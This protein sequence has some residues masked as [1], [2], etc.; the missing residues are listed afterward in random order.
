MIIDRSGDTSISY[1]YNK[2]KG[3]VLFKSIK[4]SALNRWFDKCHEQYGK[5]SKGG[6]PSVFD[7]MG[8]FT[9]IACII[10]FTLYGGAGM[11]MDGVYWVLGSL[12]AVNLLAVILSQR[13]VFWYAAL[14]Y[15]ILL[16]L[17]VLYII[18]YSAHNHVEDCETAQE[19]IKTGKAE[20]TVQCMYQGYIINHLNE[21]K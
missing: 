10:L 1:T 14:C 11:G 7:M 13:F 21:F 6:D 9:I 3:N 20:E 16:Y 18:P 12:T 2:E 19:I 8:I 5:T 15:P 17:Y 4:Q